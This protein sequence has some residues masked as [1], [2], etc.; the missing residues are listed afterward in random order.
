MPAAAQENDDGYEPVTIYFF[1]VHGCSYCERV[2]GLLGSLTVTYPD[3][4]VVDFEVYLFPENREIYRLFLERLGIKAQ[5]MPLIIIGENHWVGFREEMQ[6]QM[7]AAIEACQK[8]QCIDIGQGLVD[9]SGKLLQQA[10]G[11]NQ[12]IEF[13]VIP[14]RQ[15]VSVNLPWLGEVDLSSTSLLATTAIIGF[16]DGFNPC[17]IWVLSVL[18]SLAVYTNSRKRTMLLGLLFIFVSAVV[19]GLFITGIFSLI[20]YFS[21]LRA[22]T[23]AVS[24]IALAM[25]MINIKDYFFNK[26]GPS[27]S[28]ADDKKPG[29]YKKMRAVVIN[30]KSFP[31]LLFGT[32]A[33][34]AGVS[35]IEFSCTSGFPVIWSNL[36]ALNHVGALTYVGLL[37]VYLLIYQIDEFAIFLFAVITM[38]AIKMTEKQGRLLKLISGNSMMVL[39]GIM[40]INPDL[41]DDVFHAMIIFGCT[42]VVSLGIHLVVQRMEK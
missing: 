3:V 30:T 34:S 41:M 21:Y 10:P 16:I 18:L 20:T 13:E 22:V 15:D 29:L 37:F 26:Q 38:R 24:V 28:I 19:Y 6:E 25:G 7:I 31:G 39:G 40:V 42:L 8:T 14:Q 4:K 9:S 33:L 27:L 5:G 2:Q 36:L 23:I 35:L 12:S 32:I 17:S 11:D 1:R